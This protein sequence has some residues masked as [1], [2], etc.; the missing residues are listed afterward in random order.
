MVVKVHQLKKEFVRDL[1]KDNPPEDLVAVLTTDCNK[2]CNFCSLGPKNKI[3]NLDFYD[4][5]YTLDTNKYNSITL[6]GGEPSKH[7]LFKEMFDYALQKAD[8]V[9]VITNGS[10][11]VL[12]EKE[13]K[14]DIDRSIDLT[15][16]SLRPYADKKA[17]IDLSINPE[18]VRQQD[19]SHNHFTK[20]LVLDRAAKELN[21]RHGYNVRYYVSQEKFRDDFLKY[22]KNHSIGGA[23]GAFEIVNKG[24]YGMIYQ[25]IL[26]PDNHLFSCEHDAFVHIRNTTK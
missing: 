12:V 15:I 24:K 11:I 17:V 9:Y 23:L 16:D 19:K 13:D 7:P 14:V 4:F 26:T 18:L 10:Q 8:D 22:K 6:I 2:K 3:V 20:A 21:L 25:H 1:L 5:Q